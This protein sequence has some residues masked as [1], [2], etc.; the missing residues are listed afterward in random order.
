MLGKWYDGE[1]IRIEEVNETVRRFWVQIP[2]LESIDFKAGQFMTFDLPIH[3]KRNKRWRS[4]SISSAPDGSNILEFVIVKLEEG[5]GTTYLF[6]EVKVGSSLRLRGP[7][8]IFTFPEAHLEKELCLVCTGTGIA[9]F[10]SFLQ[11]LR[12]QQ[13]DFNRIHLVFGTRYEDG[14]LYRD[15]MNALSQE[16]DNFHYHIAL[17][18]DQNWRG[19]KGY[20]H[21]IYEQLFS[22]KR[23][24][25]FYLCG[26]NVMLDEAKERLK[27]MGYERRKHFTYEAYG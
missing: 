8:G 17:S 13:A 2:T 6:D 4:Y 19:H 16:W 23:D 5:A 22:D 26:W 15:E 20:V 7:L 12:N 1:F 10:R 11:D 24:A 25:H 21:P 18:R 27:Q 9:P 14:I 3:E